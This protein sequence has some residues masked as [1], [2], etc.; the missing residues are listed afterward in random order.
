[1]KTFDRICLGFF[2]GVTLM[3]ISRLLEGIL[4]ET[5]IFIINILLTI[6]ILSVTLFFTK[7]NDEQ[8]SS[9]VQG[10]KVNL[11]GVHIE[12]SAHG[13]DVNIKIACNSCNHTPEEITEIKNAFYEFYSVFTEVKSSK[14]LNNN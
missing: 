7:K 14:E 12:S 1:M 4:G 9:S 3:T 10:H 5:S 13:K 2:E 11:N 6:I 8:N